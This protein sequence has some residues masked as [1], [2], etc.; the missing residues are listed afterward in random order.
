MRKYIPYIALALVLI[1]LGAYFIR[2]Q[3]GTIESTILVTNNT[4]LFLANDENYNEVDFRVIVNDDTLYQGILSNEQ[5]IRKLI[6]VNLKFGTNV[7]EV[8]SDSTQLYEYLNDYV[9]WD[10]N[11]HVALGTVQDGNYF[12]L[13]IHPTYRT[14]VIN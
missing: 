9:L 1:I 8:Y 6:N 5:N 11:Y 12:N 3:F 4:E 13:K 14:L 2:F 7:I 10:K